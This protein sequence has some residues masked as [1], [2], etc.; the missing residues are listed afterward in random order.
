MNERAF[1]L[2]TD[3][4][5]ATERKPHFINDR[6]FGEDFA[7]WLQDKL[8]RVALSVS[9]PIQE[10]WGWCLVA[11]EAGRRFTV[12]V[13][14]MDDSIGQVPAEW[15]VGVS[16]ERPMNGLKGMILPVPVALLEAVGEKLHT[17]L[18]GEPSFRALQP[19]T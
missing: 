5:N 1:T 3:L 8:A 10:D 16:Y 11:T 9:D 2:W 4:F 13:G 15:R 19:A 17:V 7:A 18:A 12:S 14:V 6:C